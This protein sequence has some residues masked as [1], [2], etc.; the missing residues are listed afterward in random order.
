M[1]GDGRTAEL[2][3]S[4][5][6]MRKCVAG[7]H[8]DGRCRRQHSVGVSGVVAYRYQR[9]T[10]GA[11]QTMPDSRV[12]VIVHLYLLRI[13]VGADICICRVSKYV[14]VENSPQVPIF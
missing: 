3:N 2:R 12:W 14:C 11:L 9:C 4:S 10:Y 6:H 8:N 1:V 5:I 13:G 7:P